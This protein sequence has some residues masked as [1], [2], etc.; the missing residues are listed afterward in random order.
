MC[1]FADFDQTILGSNAQIASGVS[2]R[3]PKTPHKEV[4]F[5]H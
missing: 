2:A 3:L 4:P 1:R 5:A